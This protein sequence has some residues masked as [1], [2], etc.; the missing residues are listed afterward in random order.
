MMGVVV[1]RCCSCSTATAAA[2][3]SPPCAEASCTERR[4]T[5]KRRG[6]THKDADKLPRALLHQRRAWHYGIAAAAWTRAAAACKAV[7]AL[8]QQRSCQR[9]TTTQHRRAGAR[10]TAAGSCVPRREWRWRACCVMCL[11]TTSGCQ[12]QKRDATAT[13]LAAAAP[14]QAL[15][16]VAA[17][18]QACR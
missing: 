12:V 14:L 6:G 16:A 3:Y 13:A 4:A 2:A 15:N 18:W 1:G 7:Q 9:R 11:S 8:Q 5:T 10:V 17:A